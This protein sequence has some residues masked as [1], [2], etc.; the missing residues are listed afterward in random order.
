LND[1]LAWFNSLPDEEAR[2]R[3]LVCNGSRAWAKAIAARRPY[4]D[5]DALMT[6]ADSVWSELKPS[7]WLEAFAAHPRLGESGGHAPDTSQKEQSRIM[8][9]GNQTLAALAAENRR[10]ETR[11]GHVFLIS[12]AGRTA[13]DVLA[14]LR[15]RIDNDPATELHVA[16]EEQRKITRLRLEGLLSR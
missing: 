4:A 16:A 14:I 13:P 8:D 10:Y 12:A 1:G 7:D 3:L 6:A 5:V 11:F 2:T 9:A 15:Q